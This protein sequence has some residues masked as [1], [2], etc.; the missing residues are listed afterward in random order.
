MA[1]KKIVFV[2]VEGPSDDE[3]IGTMLS[4]MLDKN[5]VY[6]QIIHGDITTQHGVTNSNI[7]AKIGT[8]VQN[9]AKNNHFKKNKEKKKEVM[10]K[11]D[12]SLKAGKYQ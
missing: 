3:V 8:I 2:I 1:R 7:L 11:K 10:E 5:E 9:Y 4:R 6:V 12:G